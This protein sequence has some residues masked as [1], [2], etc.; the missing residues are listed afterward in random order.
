MCC[1]TWRFCSGR[2]GLDAAAAASTGPT[3]PVVGNRC[4]IFYSADSETVPG[5]HSDGCLCAWT[6]G[7]GHVAA[8]G[9][10]AY[11]K[12]GYALVLGDFGGCSCGLHCCVRCSL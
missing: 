11:V 3:G 7:S 2:A 10:D 5:E 4:N 12:R 1:R 9:S 8:G 6:R